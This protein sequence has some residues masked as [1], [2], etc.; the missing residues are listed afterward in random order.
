M[1]VKASIRETVR[2]NANA[3]DHQEFRS[4]FMIAFPSFLHLLP[5]LLEEAPDEDVPRVAIVAACW[6]ER[7]TH[8]REPL[9]VGCNVGEAAGLN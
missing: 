9:S 3:V 5:Q 7:Q 8:H 4:R 6:R 1:D 2:R